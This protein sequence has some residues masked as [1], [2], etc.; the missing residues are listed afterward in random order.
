M[1]YELSPNYR[2]FLFRKDTGIAFMLSL[3]ALLYVVK[4]LTI[5]S[6]KFYPTIYRVTYIQF[7][8][9]PVT[10]SFFA[11]N[12]II[13]ALGLAL[14]SLIVNSRM[15]AI[16]GSAAVFT[17]ALVTGLLQFSILSQAFALATVP[18]IIA[19]IAVDRMAAR[20][21]L[22]MHIPL[23]TLA[24][25][26]VMMVFVFE[27]LVLLRWASY[28]LLPSKIYGDWTWSV[29]K[30]DMRVFYVFGLLS[31]L[32]MLLMVYAFLIKP[33]L[34]DIRGFVTARIPA[35][36]RYGIDE[37][38]EVKEDLNSNSSSYE[39]R[40]V[41]IFN[42]RSVSRL[43]LGASF[44]LSII[45]SVYP[46]LPSINPDF[47][48]AG[49]DVPFYVDW[50][51]VL[52]N[53]DK[54]NSPSHNPFLDIARGD[55]PLSLLLMFSLQ[56]VT[57][58]SSQLIGRFLP[59]L[60]GP[61]LIVAVYYFVKFGTSNKNIAALSALITVVSYHFVVGMYAGFFANWLALVSSYVSL[62]FLLRAWEKPG[63]LHYLVFLSLT[64]LTL[65]IHV[66]T[67]SYLMASIILFLSIS[68]V[69]HRKQHAKI[70]TVGILG[71]IVAANI[72]LDFV[73]TNYLGAAGGLESDV[74]L[75][76]N[77]AGIQQFLLRWNNLQYTFHTYV[78][79]Y[80]TNAA[81]LILAFIWV[82]RARYENSFD[83]ILLASMFVG[84]L[85]I[86]FGNYI[87]QT[88]IFYNMPIHIP[89]A[90]MLYSTIT[91][92]RLHPMLS[93]VLSFTIL[94]H[95]INYALRSLSNLYLILP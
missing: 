95:F 37:M 10:G 67:W 23:Q 36:R 69:I 94:V 31:P 91:N 13:L 93:S 12:M 65:F 77:W 66:Y 38:N 2:N 44:A 55:R 43:M 84:A 18:S 53:P 39:S 62:L 26:T 32:V 68:Y 59:L 88:R 63:K 16:A 85:P 9:E 61:M 40:N 14:I 46:Y 41:S 33:Y 60:L 87:M 30:L 11:D 83:R 1:K 35:F 74:K 17:S 81:M 51:N 20:N 8:N 58:L 56:S 92:Y 86:I 73:K 29:A 22:R 89:A 52:Q 34:K 76:Q 27:V 42:K 71:V 48:V 70:I 24:I 21:L 7:F 64:M 45:F 78:G 19:L 47:K 28:P 75:A 82:L 3:L 90:M 25:T 5:A 54:Y 6:V 4:L 79:G 50:I 49:V 80:F 57:G 72:V 15:Y